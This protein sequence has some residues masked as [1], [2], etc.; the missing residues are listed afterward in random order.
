MLQEVSDEPPQWIRIWSWTDPLPCFIN[1]Q[2]SHTVG[3]P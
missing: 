2:A 3:V 1:F